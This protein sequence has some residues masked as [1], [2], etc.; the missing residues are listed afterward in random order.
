VIGRAWFRADGKL[1]AS[2]QHGRLQFT[3][4]GL[5]S[6]GGWKSVSYSY[7]SS[8]PSSTKKLEAVILADNNPKMPWYVGSK[9]RAIFA[10][11]AN[12]LLG[13]D[14]G[15]LIPPKLQAELYRLLSRLPGAHFDLTTDLAGRHGM[16]FFMRFGWYKQEIVINPATYA[17]MGDEFVAIKAHT[18]VALDG[19]WHIKKGHVLGWGAV[20]RIAVV[21]RAGQLP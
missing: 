7:L 4:A 16:G 11:I 6:M 20:I 9:N 2:Y 8:L 15:V 14:N 10:A 12:L 18:S 19:T 17:Y 5:A 21:Q 3:P 13:E 1:D